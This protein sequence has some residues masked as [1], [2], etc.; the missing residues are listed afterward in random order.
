M[1]FAKARKV[2]YFVCAFPLKL[3]S[4]LDSAIHEHN[5]FDQIHLSFPLCPPLT[6]SFP[7]HSPP[8]FMPM[9]T[10][11]DIKHTYGLAGSLIRVA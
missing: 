10:Y 9:Y 5:V 11:M 7:A 2:T 3:N 4:V 8:M 6:L 1:A